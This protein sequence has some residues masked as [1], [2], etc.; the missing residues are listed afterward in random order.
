MRLSFIDWRMLTEGSIRRG[1]L[2]ETFGV[3]MAQASGDINNFI[4]AY[5]DA[6]SYD[7]T[8][9]QYVPANGRY[10]S[11]TGWTPRKLAAWAAAAAA[12]CEWAWR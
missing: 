4:R 6:L 8:V 9:K 7:K 3:S 12:G 10:R 5:P 11:V 1:H 2:V